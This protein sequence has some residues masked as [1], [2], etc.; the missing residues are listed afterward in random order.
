[1]IAGGGREERRREYRQDVHLVVGGCEG[2]AEASSVKN[3]HFDG[4][5]TGVGVREGSVLR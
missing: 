2:N 1:M 3:D 4:Q 5:S